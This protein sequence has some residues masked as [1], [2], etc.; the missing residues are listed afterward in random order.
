MS[1]NTKYI[2]ISVALSQELPVWPGGYGFT[3]HQIT[4]I[5][6]G[7]EANVTRLDFDVHSGTHI[8]A[9]LHFIN[10][11]KTTEELPLELMMGQTLV[12]TFENKNVIT[13]EDIDEKSV[14]N[15]IKR[16]ILKTNN[17]KNLWHTKPFDKDFVAID[18]RVAQWIVDKGINFIGIDGPSIQK[19][20]DTKETHVKLLKNEVIILEGLN[21]LEVEEGIYELICLPIKA[22]DCEGIPV[23][24]ILKKNE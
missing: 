20:Y 18:S 6:A 21:L 15:N 13:L 19:F 11:G 3:K 16:L 5:R 22:A 23:R 10:N 7:H 12:L 9:P 4:S 24:A 17:S 1:F 14:P 8:D 2:D